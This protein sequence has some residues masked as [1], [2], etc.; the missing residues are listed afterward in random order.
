MIYFIWKINS[1]AFS[2]VPF[3]N[4]FCIVIPLTQLNH[5]T[6]IITVTSHR[7][8]EF[9]RVSRSVLISVCFFCI[10]SVSRL[11]QIT[12]SYFDS[13]SNMTLSDFKTSCRFY[14]SLIIFVLVHFVAGHTSPL[15]LLRDSPSDLLWR[16]ERESIRRVMDSMS[17]GCRIPASSVII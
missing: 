14:S 10:R 3:K 4:I 5:L 12:H 11:F 6:Q 8:Y 2:S 16:G 13:S 15:S 1:N 9:N 17:S 7:R